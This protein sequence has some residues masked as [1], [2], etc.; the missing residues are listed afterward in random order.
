M[1]DNP[2]FIKVHSI[3]LQK[4]LDDFAKYSPNDAVNRKIAFAKVE[5][6]VEFY[7]E[8]EANL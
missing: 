7:T 4:Y 8:L 2:V 5:A 1:I 3:L 6:L